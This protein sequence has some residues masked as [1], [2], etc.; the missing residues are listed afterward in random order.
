M[1]SICM[2]LLGGEDMSWTI[3]K[4]IV[5]G[6][7][8]VLFAGLALGALSRGDY[9][10]HFVT[11]DGTVIAGITA[12]GRLDTL[13]GVNFGEGKFTVAGA[14]GNTTIAGT[15]GVDGAVTLSSTLTTTGALVSG[16]T[17]TTAGGL[18]INDGTSG[19]VFTVAGATGNTAIAGT[20]DVVGTL[21]LG[22][23]ASA[24][25]LTLYPATITSGTTT[26]TMADNVGDTITNINV[27]AQAGARTYTIPDTGALASEFLLTDAF[28]TTWAFGI[29]LAGMDTDGAGTNGGG[30]AGGAVDLTTHQYNDGG[31]D[32]YVKV[33]DQSMDGGAGTWA[34]LAN[35]TDLD[36]ITVA[37]QLQPDADK[38]A[39]D[40]AFAIGFDTQFCQ[41]A[42]DDLA[43]GTGAVATYS[44]DTGKWQYSDGAGSWTDLTPVFD[45]TDSTAQDGLRTLQRTGAISFAPPADWVAVTI[46]GQEAYWVQWVVTAAE[47]TQSA[48]IDSTN[49]DE[50]FVVIPNADTFSA[51]FKG[52]ISVVRVSNF[53][54]TVH[55]QD[56][57][58]IVGNFTTGVFSEELTWPASQYNDKFT[59]ATALEV[60]ADDLVGIL[61][62][63]DNGS[64]NNPI[65]MLELEATYTD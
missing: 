31:G 6:L 17:S 53:H 40:D 18:T 61:V 56:V 28:N 2:Q 20:L 14:T 51:P 42:F 49:K 21:T 62:T 64:T 39:I 8:L 59:L 35:S 41:I 7:A 57:T 11:P 65:W 46:D 47:L 10:I 26:L 55:D 12:T 44:N 30:I 50:P 22:E 15:L 29:G 38:E 9:R 52:E 13:L 24:G 16:D 34:D 3:R 60:S 63:N 25:T 1:Y 36:S 32:V 5:G 54:A 33:F 45:N 27:A 43:T 37:Y 23:D 48:G 4:W 19:A 58:F